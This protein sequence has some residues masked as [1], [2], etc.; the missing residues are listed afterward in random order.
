V[1]A[2]ALVVFAVYEVPL[3]CSGHPSQAGVV[4]VVVPAVRL[5]E[6]VVRTD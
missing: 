2:V 4:P 1:L 5:W 3:V 6:F